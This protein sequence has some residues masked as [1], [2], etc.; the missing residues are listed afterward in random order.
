[1]LSIKKT[2]RWIIYFS[3]AVLTIVVMTAATIRLV[4]FPNIN[5]YKNDVAAMITKKIGLRTT[6]GNIVTGWDGLS[7][8]ILIREINIYDSDNQPALHLE[9]VNGTFS[10]LSLPMLS[11]HLSHISVSN[12]TLSVKRTKTGAIYIAGIA[13]AG[14][15]KPDFANWL[16][17]Q[18][19]IDINNAAIV[20]HDE[21]RQAP[22]LSLNAVDFNL[23][24]PAWR[25]IFGQHLFS[26]HAL[27]STG[28]QYP[29]LLNG[30]FF[31]RDITKIDTWHGEVSLSAKSIDLTAWK[32]WFDYPIDLQSGLGKADVTLTFADQAI[33]RLTANVQL[34]QLSAKLNTST[35]WLN[36]SALSGV[37]SWEETKNTTTLSGQQIKL[38]TDDG[39]HIKN[40]SGF[41]S[42][43]I[44][45]QQPWLNAALSLD[46][47]DLSYLGKI[48]KIVKLPEHIQQP[49]NTLNPQGKLS[50]LS[51]RFEGNPKRPSHF[52]IESEFTSLSVQPY[53]K[54][55]GFSNL[56]GEI[57]TNENKGTLLLSSTNAVLHLKDILRWPIPINTLSGKI[58]WNNHN[59]IVNIFASNVAIANDHMAGTINGNYLMNKIKGGYLDLNA[60][61]ERGDAQFASFYY[62]LSLGEKS[63]NWLDTAILSGKANDIQ[64]KVKGKLDD[65]PYVDKQNK[66]NPSLGAFKVT[67]RINDATLQYGKDWPRLEKLGLNMRFEGNSMEL[68]ADTGNILD[69][70]IIKAKAII[71]ALNT[72]GTMAQALR[73]D[74]ISEGPVAAGIALINNSPIKQVT[75][76]FTD[77]LKT[78]GK[79]KLDMNIEIPL[80]N[81]VDTQYKGEYLI[82]NGA[83][84]ANERLGLPEISMI[85]G[86][87]RFDGSGIHARAVNANVLGG[88]AQFDVTT[89]ENKTINIHAKGLMTASGIQQ[90]NDNT[91]TKAFNGSAGWSTDIA[92]KQ[93]LINLTIRSNLKGLAINL[94]SPLG[95]H[96]SEEASLT[97]Q[98]QQFRAEEDSINID[99]KQAVSAI[100][101]RK[102]KND[103]L[104]FDGG[105]IAI[106]MPAKAPTKPG[107]ALRGQLDYFDADEWLALPSNQDNS[108]NLSHV[109]FNSAALSIQQLN[110]FNRSF[111]GL[112]VSSSPSDRHLQMTVNS[113]EING[114]I[115]W[116]SPTKTQATGA[117]IARLNKL[118]IPASND[119][120]QTDTKQTEIKK[121]DNH[122][123]ALDIQVDD[124]KLGKKELGRFAL[125]AYQANDDW[126]IQQLKIS[127]PDHVLMAEGRWFNWTSSPNTNLVFSLTANDVGNTLKRF[128][129]PDVIKGGVALIAGQL[130]W[131]GSPHQFQSKGLNG[132]LQLGASKGQIVKVKPG[133][134][135]L[136]GL[137]TLQSLPRRLTLDFRD[138]FSEG[139]AFDEISGNANI[140]DGIMHSNDF[141]MT[142]PAAETKIKGDI[143]LNKE[144]QY[145]HIKVIPH[146]S[147]SFSLAALAG[148]PIV[149]AAAFVAQKLLKDPLNKI[150]QSEYTIVGT[151]DN[152]VEVGAEKMQPDK[153]PTNSPLNSQ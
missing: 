128:G 111:Y 122:Y 116:R 23:H 39:F 151:W 52:A 136:F 143:D 110:I 139:F 131:P 117:L 86:T 13:I 121:L 79:A 5:D 45:H 26:M 50:K 76:G 130:N 138:L 34:N 77:D 91:L 144:T 127:N 24:N 96:S 25:K 35:E 71:P 62:P 141:F 132:E 145:L 69:L 58:Y 32:A 48:Q 129:Q 61:F 134:G 19:S 118:Y 51:M 43:S 113:Q 95:K 85:N 10:W 28:T 140:T 11:P 124:F 83:M 14:E 40:G 149:G 1:M 103:G 44:K 55:P 70:N 8:K 65:F 16:L 153:Q 115:E 31:G 73:I 59:E 90:L 98:K 148:G 12:P 57:K 146:I 106:N 37:L 107:L 108:S 105:D 80:N 142:G 27:P 100:L 137:L 63:L 29:I 81:I 87:L 92:I 15:G 88:P 68:T 125:N 36:A 75:L 56:S 4:I 54:I 74:A 102:Q 97:I 7:P 9:N 22:A 82:N 84:Y 94:P 93:P 152:P 109:P 53:Q 18:A 30:H 60:Q 78:S 41:F 47:F 21:L 114:E 49:I 66:P 33:N 20:W 38:D 120:D 104:Q 101:V 123:P 46:E 42:Q 17:S 64:L 112:N 72:N 119:I 126:V 133:V 99:Y 147:D 135:R 67:A 6:V 3:L 89:A 2:P 150:A